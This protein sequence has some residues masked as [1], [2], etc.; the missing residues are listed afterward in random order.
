[1]YAQL[2]PT[3]FDP[4]GC[5]PA[6]S[7]VHGSLQARIENRSGLPCPP[8][9]DLPYPGIK[10]ASLMPPTLAGRFFIPSAT[11]EAILE[12]PA[13]AGLGNLW[14][15]NW[16]LLPWKHSFA[17]LWFFSLGE[18]RVIAAATYLLRVGKTF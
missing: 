3:L 10:P 15:R 2:L 9:G 16:K 8:P 14:R 13:L 7:S 1:M 4:L 12:D 18:E 17:A 6:D 11:W 5:D